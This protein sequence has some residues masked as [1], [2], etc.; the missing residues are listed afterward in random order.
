MLSE[1]PACS[2]RKHRAVLGAVQAGGCSSTPPRSTQPT[3]TPTTTPRPRPKAPPQP[4]HS[5]RSTHPTPTRPTMR[6]RH[7]GRPQP[8]LSQDRPKVPTQPGPSLATQL[9][10]GLSTPMHSRTMQRHH[11]ISS[12]SMPPHRSSSP[13]LR[14]GAP[15]PGRN[16]LRCR[17]LGLSSHSPRQRA[18]R[19][20][21][22]P[23]T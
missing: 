1:L 8:G 11:T 14:V 21:A 13:T 18:A 5:Q 4:G 20:M 16:S 15:T 23:T 17:G 12:T 19:G 6:L 10:M 9:A 7:R 2:S 3:T 22:S